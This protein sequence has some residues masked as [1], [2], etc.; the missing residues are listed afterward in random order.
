MLACQPNGWTRHHIAHLIEPDCAPRSWNALR[1]DAAL[2]QPLDLG[3]GHAR[4]DDAHAFGADQRANR[5]A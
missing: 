4:L 1:D 5:P 3:I 2:R